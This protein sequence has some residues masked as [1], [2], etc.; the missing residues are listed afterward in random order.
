[1]NQNSK[2]L[3]IEPH[4]EINYIDK[5]SGDPIIFIPGLTFSTDFFE[6]QI[7]HFSKT[8]RVI[9][10]DP[11]SQGRSSKVLHGNDYTTHGQDLAKIID[12][13]ELNNITLV[14]WS[15]GNLTVWSYVNQ[16]G[17]EKI[18]A[19]A[20]IDMSPKPLSVNESDWVEGS[21]DE[22]CEVTTSILNSQE[23]QR[24]FF[25]DYATQVMV[26]RKLTKEELL[27]IVDTSCKTPFYITHNLFTNAVMG[28]FRD[29]C[30]K[31]ND[32][33]P[34]IMF[35]AEHWADIAKPYMKNNYPKITTCV[36]GGHLMFWEYPERFNEELSQFLNI[37]A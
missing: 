28:D 33:V 19:A 2:F 4:V 16:F 23:G 32:E 35:I 13:L 24:A 15:T 6:A 17:T 3:E 1:M 22:L 18:K 36:M 7:S 20:L 10:I 14:G 9:A 26:Q 25:T 37:R 11:R 29:G 30:K 34:T 5:G 31:L 27:H 12:M 21:I 8:N